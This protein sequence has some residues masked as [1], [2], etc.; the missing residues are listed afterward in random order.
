MESYFMLIVCH[1]P[2]S[3]VDVVS[4][5]SFLFSLFLT[6]L[7][8]FFFLFNNLSFAYF[9]KICCVCLCLKGLRNGSP[10]SHF[11]WK[12]NLFISHNSDVEIWKCGN[13]NISKCYAHLCY[14]SRF[15]IQW[16]IAFS[17]LHFLFILRF[18]SFIHVFSVLFWIWAPLRFCFFFFFGGSF[19]CYCRFLSVCAKA[20]CHLIYKT[21]QSVH[22][23]WPMDEDLF[24]S[25][26]S[27][28]LSIPM[29]KK[30]IQSF[31]K[32]VRLSVCS[33]FTRV[34]LIVLDLNGFAKPPVKGH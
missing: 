21:E 9:C 27:Q 16:T 12:I 20:H 23:T 4:L 28:L 2:V 18:S 31:C 29:Y 26:F 19:C 15:G 10:N 3:R 32:V 22:I 25:T 33:T 7:L 17:F 6:F 5:F 30:V 13:T 8:S 11:I 34:E 24:S 1:F 14:G